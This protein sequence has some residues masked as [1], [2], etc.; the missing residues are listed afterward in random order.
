MAP[1][2]NPRRNRPRGIQ[3]RRGAREAVG[4]LTVLALVLTGAVT[5]A[6]A[7]AAELARNL[8]AATLAK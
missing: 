2:L 7:S 4:L 3:N 8:A 5:P 6:E 1:Q